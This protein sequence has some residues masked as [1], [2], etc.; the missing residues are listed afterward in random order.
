MI[1]FGML[2]HDLACL[3]TIWHATARHQ[4]IDGIA[5]SAEVVMLNTM[6]KTEN[7]LITSPHPSLHANETWR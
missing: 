3:G 7:P 6:M 1:D 5:C 2:W 4:G